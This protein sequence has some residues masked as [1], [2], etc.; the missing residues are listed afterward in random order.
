LKI[1]ENESEEVVK[2]RIFGDHKHFMFPGLKENKNLA[3][4]DSLFDKIYAAT[5]DKTY[6]ITKFDLI[7]GNPPWGYEYNDWQKAAIRKQWPEVSK[8]QSSQI[9]L[10]AI[11]K[12]MK[13]DSI[14]GMVVN[15]SN[16]TSDTVDFRQSFLRKFSL[17]L[18][19]S[20]SKIKDITFVVSSEPGCV[21]IFDCVQSEA[22]EF[23]NPE[24]N[25][26]S[27]LTHFISEGEIAKV[28]IHNL[29]QYDYLWHVYALGL[30]KFVDL[31][32]SI[33]Q[34][35]L[36]FDYYVQ[37]SSVGI[38]K[39]SEEKSRLT[40]KEF[41]EKYSASYKK[42]DNYYPMVDTL[43]NTKPF[44]EP[45]GRYHFEW[46]QHL[47]RA[48]NLNL[49]IGDKLVVTRNWPLKAFVSSETRLFDGNFCIFKLTSKYSLDDLK[50]FEAIFNSKLARFYL[51]VKYHLRSSGNFPKINLDHIRV[52]P[53]P[54]IKTNLSNDLSI[55]ASIVNS[56]ELIKTALEDEEKRLVDEIDRLVYKLYNLD[57]YSIQ[58]VDHYIKTE[59][60][61]YGE[62]SYREI[63][64]YCEEFERIFKP[65]LKEKLLLNADCEIS[66]FIGVIVRF[67]VSTEKRQFNANNREL[68]SFLKIIERNKIKEY[69]RKKYFKEEKIKFY[70]NNQLW[71]YK[72]RNPK[73]WTALMA[74]NDANEEIKVFFEAVTG[75]H[76]V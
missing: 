32:Q 42:N 56:V 66:D 14:C 33:D 50:L 72:S 9:F 37:D 23:A 17:H 63:F 34:S 35:P 13:A 71:I 41:Y 67:T 69:T 65:F 3:E 24:L 70:D 38:M 2:E 19:A 48:R 52:F 55:V 53:M 57:Y 59:E 4:G 49:F 6:P 58:E 25:Q 40:K 10:L 1:I 54:D 39:Y 21:L 7:I 8:Y 44:H 28:S 30:S 43:K 68:K 51:G 12:W 31:I 64:A 36:K 73:D 18:F 74:I 47:D 26:F 29:R 16:F 76:N 62:I 5:L 22:I 60:L 46:G 15:L 45:E 61:K 27:I 75:V 20:L 11:K